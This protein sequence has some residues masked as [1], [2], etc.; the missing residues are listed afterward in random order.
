MP[1]EC[2]LLCMW[3]RRVASTTRTYLVEMDGSKSCRAIRVS[4]DS[5]RG[6]RG[7]LRSRRRS[8]FRRRRADMESRVGHHVPKK[9][10]GVTG[11]NSF[12]RSANDFVF[13]CFSN[14]KISSK[15]VPAT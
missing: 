15:R 5:V 1:T 10:K 3:N 13:M 7:Q 9:E 8:Y 11:Q 4:Y 12:E 2:L 14:S 6:A